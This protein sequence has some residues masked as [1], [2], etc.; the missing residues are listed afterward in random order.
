LRTLADSGP[1]PQS[2][3]FPTADKVAKH[4]FSITALGT[5]AYLLR[6]EEALGRREGWRQVSPYLPE[7]VRRNGGRKDRIT[8][9]VD[10]KGL[11]MECVIDNKPASWQW[12]GHQDDD[13]EQQS[14]KGLVEVLNESLGVIS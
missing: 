14:A 10:G 12:R 11:S 8:I 6:E 7:L 3:Q 9:S 4:L 13:D 5:I 2:L 1:L